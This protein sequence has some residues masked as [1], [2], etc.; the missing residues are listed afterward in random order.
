MHPLFIFAHIISHV[1]GAKSFVTV[2]CSPMRSFHMLFLIDV[3]RASK[4]QKRKTESEERNKKG[5]Q[6]D[7]A[8]LGKRISESR[9][10]KFLAISEKR[11]R[12]RFSNF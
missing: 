2:E 4:S 8:C 12:D 10:E 11:E 3:C 9:G 5:E 7:K 1:R 6:I